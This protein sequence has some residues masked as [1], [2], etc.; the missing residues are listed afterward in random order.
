MS[1]KNYVINVKTKAGTIFTVRADSAA[2]LNAH[3]QDVIN[4]ATNQVVVALE[5]LFT[6]D[7]TVVPQAVPQAVQ[8]VQ[9]VLGGQVIET[10]PN[11]TVTPANI[12]VSAPAPHPHQSQEQTK[13][14]APSCRHGQMVHVNPANKP[15]SGYFCPQP[16]EATDKCTPVFDKN[17]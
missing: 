13:P 11:V 14:A 4:N 17:K 1:E 5:Q 7:T 9:A 3:V 16:K 6:G 15:W 10:V 8:T 12:P 2:E